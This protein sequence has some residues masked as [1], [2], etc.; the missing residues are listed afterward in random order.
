MQRDTSL[1]LGCV[2]WRA[3]CES[4]LAAGLFV[5]VEQTCA[6]PMLP[7]QLFRR[8]VFRA[9]AL[10]GLLVNVAFYGLIF[11]FSLYIQQLNGLSP[12]ATG[13]AFLPMMGAVF[14][15]NLWAARAAER[16][17]QRTAI[18]LA[19]ALAAA[20]CLALLG[21]AQ[22][23][24]Y[25]ALARQLVAL[26]LGLGRLVPVLTARLLDSVEKSHS[27]VA[28]GVLNAMRQTG[29]VVRGALRLADRRRARVRGR[30]PPDAADHDRPAAGRL[31]RAAGG[32]YA[33]LA[34]A[35]AHGSVR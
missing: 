4:A 19:Q 33:L 22:G 5:R 8:P 27:G 7:P 16:L 3:F 26:G 12:L 29:S 34:A 17:G 23:T 30:R 13:L 14:P 9:S 35:I 25:A 15:T 32:R 18:V 2:E 6:T 10:D 11:V 1:K 20:G 28:S 24:R 31:R 21:L